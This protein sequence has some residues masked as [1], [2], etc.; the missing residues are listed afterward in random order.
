MSGNTG[1]RRIVGDV[2]GGTCASMKQNA[3][4]T[5]AAAA[6]SIRTNFAHTVGRRE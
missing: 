6:L 2:T 3:L 1:T 5:G 4:R